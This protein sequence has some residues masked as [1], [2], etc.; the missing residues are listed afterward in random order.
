[1]N[2]P[3]AL[4]IFQNLTQHGYDVFFDFNGIASGDFERI[5]LGNIEA[6]AHFIVLLTP[7]AL[8]GCS[9]PDDWLRRE[10]ETALRIRRNIVPIIMDGFDFGTPGIANQLTGTLASLRN[11]NS[12]RVPVEYFMEAMARLRDKY[13]NIALD[14]VFHPAPRLV[15]QAASAQ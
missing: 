6:R 7:S 1:T 12:L 3:W 10:V 8:G 9:K 13:L 11:Y 14:A 15:Q 5:I 4:A 2:A